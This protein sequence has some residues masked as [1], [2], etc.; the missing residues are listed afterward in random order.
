MA[1]ISFQLNNS[2][3][4]LFGKARTQTLRFTLALLLSLLVMV[5]D[6]R[7]HGLKT[8]HNALSAIV[9]PLQ[10]A[11]DYP[12]RVLG[13]FG[14][15]VRSKRVLIQDNMRLRYQHTLLQADLQRLMAIR[16]EN[17]QLK[18]LLLTASRVKMKAMAAQVLAVDPTSSRQLLILDKGTRD[19]VYVGQAVLDAQGVMG[20]II[21][22]GHLTST[23]MLI[24]DA[25]CAVPVRNNR[26][27]ERAILIGK[28]RLEEL[29]LINLP[30]TSSIVKGDLLVTSGLGRLYPEGYPVGRVTAVHS[31]PGEAFIK[32]SVAPVASLNRNRLVL[33]IWLGKEQAVLT[34]QIDERLKKME[35]MA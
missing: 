33:L 21:D 9:A 28:N 15:L 3:K 22:A 27:G 20:Q 10:Y 34:G 23:V 30:R 31:L 6:Y 17:T 32:V 29:S 5:A 35:K 1:V 8:L 12:A 18:E 25:K 2:K 26:T 7:T 16:E 14:A 4:S 19:G 13:W 11:V 24:S